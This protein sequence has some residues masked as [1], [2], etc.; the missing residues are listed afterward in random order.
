LSLQRTINLVKVQQE[1]IEVIEKIIIKSHTNTSTKIEKPGERPPPS[2]KPPKKRGNLQ[3][4]IHNTN[5]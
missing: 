2:P 4:R 3:F 1:R 5:L